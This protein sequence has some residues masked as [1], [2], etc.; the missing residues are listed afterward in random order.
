M[1]VLF[2]HVDLSSGVVTTKE[3]GSEQVKGKR[4][5]EGNERRTKG[6]IA[7]RMRSIVSKASTAGYIRVVLTFA[8]QKR[9]DKKHTL[10]SVSEGDRQR[11]EE[12]KIEVVQGAERGTK[13]EK[14]AVL[15]NGIARRLSKAP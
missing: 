8:S 4:E 12:M 3:R 13:M 11:E 9:T 7:D 6:V 5:N 10:C 2:V 15:A 14:L 1:Q